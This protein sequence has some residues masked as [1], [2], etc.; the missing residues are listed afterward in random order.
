MS[1]KIQRTDTVKSL[2]K[3]RII[4]L[5]AFVF[6][7]TGYWFTGY[8]NS[9]ISTDKYPDSFFQIIYLGAAL[10]SFVAAVIIIYHSIRS[11]SWRERAVFI[12]LVG[13]SLVTALGNLFA[14]LMVGAFTN[15]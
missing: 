4:S 12:I 11:V 13:I 9:S 6:A 14:G 10:L 5:I 3:T 8:V 1:K 7:V 2:H 15:F